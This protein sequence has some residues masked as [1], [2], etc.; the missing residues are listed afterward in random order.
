MDAR[1][2]AEQGLEGCHR[3]PAA[4]EAEGE[5]VEVGLEVIVP[6]AVV[7]PT[8]PRLE[9]AK[10]PMDVR[11]ELASAVGWALSAG[12]MVVAEFRERGVPLP[13]VSED[14]GPG[15]DGVSHEPRERSR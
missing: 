10:H 11:Q 8:Q 14:D 6:D 7:G 13:P 15:G 3:G 1:G 12:A 5:L 9:M 2:E 4:V